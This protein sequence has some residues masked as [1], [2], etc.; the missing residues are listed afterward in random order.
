MLKIIQSPA[1]GELENTNIFVNAT[2]FRADIQT[3]N[4]YEHYI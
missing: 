3:C 1:C 2:D 4:K